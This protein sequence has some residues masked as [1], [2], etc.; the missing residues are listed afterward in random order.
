MVRDGK[1]PKHIGAMV[2]MVKRFIPVGLF[3]CFGGACIGQ[4]I[5]EQN[6]ILGLVGMMLVFFAG[7]S[8]EYMYTPTNFI[9]WLRK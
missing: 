4:S 7:I 9:S 8:M 2:L 3:G 6:L 1:R 5:R